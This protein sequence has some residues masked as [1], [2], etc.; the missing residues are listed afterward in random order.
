M[1]NNN[2]T[3][4]ALGA[5][6][7]ALDGDSWTPEGVRAMAQNTEYVLSALGTAF[8]RARQ[9]NRAP[10]LDTCL[11]DLEGSLELSAVD[12]D[13]LASNADE[14]LGGGQRWP[15]TCPTSGPWST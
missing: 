14:I 7:R 6:A 10:S 2:S 4:D 15:S 1:S 13:R 12:A 11:R 5:L 9:R 3:A 8:S